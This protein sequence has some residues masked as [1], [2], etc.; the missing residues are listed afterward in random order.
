M[1]PRQEDQAQLES[2][3]GMTALD[4]RANAGTTSVREVHRF[5]EAALGRWMERHVAGFSGALTVTQFKG[6][7]SNPTY[8]LGTRERAYV[9]RR[10]PPG[11]L[12]KGAH[13]VQREARIL[14]A[15]S[16][17]DVP[18]ARVD[19][20]CADAS[21]IG[22]PFFIMEMVEG[23]IFWDATFADV[24]RDDRAGYFDAMNATIA[25]LHAVDHEAVGL[26]DHGRP[27][28]YFARQIARWSQQYLEDEDA[29][30]D[31]DMDALVA[32]LPANIPAGDETRIV[33]GDFRCDN[34]IFHPTEP[35][36]LAVLDWEL[37]T[38]GHPL[39]DFAYHAI[40]YR[41]PPDIVAGLAGADLAALRIPSESD[42]VA[43]YCARTD[44]AG[45]PDYDFHIAF[46]FF[47]LA[48]I[49]HGI[50]GRVL[51]GTAA[52][53]HARER[54]ASFPRLARLARDA[55]EGRR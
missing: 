50:K 37:S 22:T 9:L 32:W 29:D 31:A 36:I 21:V 26:G 52:S 13:D 16:A 10:S 49:F 1:E 38:L 45:I 34:L 5:D 39:A 47:R 48:A 25:A 7:Q 17:T 4:E 42:Y 11:P 55:M 23:R 14:S 40:M 24:P 46:N 18:V 33:H 51:R 6:G 27:G 43:A 3:T 30:R 12:V 54:A 8:R 20:I 53:A 35:R 15:L 28:N 41:M 44:R 2:G 19:G